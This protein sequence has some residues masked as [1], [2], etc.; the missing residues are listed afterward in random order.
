MLAINR[1]FMPRF[2]DDNFHQAMR[3][4]SERASSPR[5][6]VSEFDENFVI[7]LAAPG[8]DKDS[9][10]VEIHDNTLSIKSEA[11]KDNEAKSNKF[12]MKEFSYGSFERTFTIN[13]EL[14][15][16]DNVSASYHNGILYV[17]LAK[18]KTVEKTPKKIAVS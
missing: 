15:D 7:E 1:N 3:N 2:F 6:N 14:V 4:H 18:N 10:E 9:F 8:Y 5:V 13:T 12:T 16:Q 11:K 17:T